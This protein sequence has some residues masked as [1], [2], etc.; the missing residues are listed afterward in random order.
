[1]SDNKYRVIVVEDES[2][3]AK[4]IAKHIE[5]ENPNFKVIGIYSNGEDA[6]CAVKEE[7]PEVVFTDISMPVMTGLELASK[8]HESFSH[9]RCV[10]LTG[11]ADFEYAKE[12]L[13][14]N[15]NDYLLKPLDTEE[16]RKVLKNLELSL[17]AV[18]ADVIKNS[19]DAGYTPEE[20]VTI[21]KEYVQK[22]YAGELDLN[23]I[24]DNLGFSSSY[25][26]KVFNKVE[27]ITP[28]KY[29][30]NYRMGIA[31]QLLLNK[32]LTIAQ[33]AE[34]VGYNDPFH[35][36]KSFKQTYGISPTD[37]RKPSSTL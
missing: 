2:L 16:L 17:S 18:S 31:K 3:I 36:S 8:I 19:S 26:T 35:F 6:F 22:N 33:V 28:S 15:V 14:Y 10:I 21:V 24:A 34:C 11:Y 29:I 37:I 7:L 1:M 4:N 5:K 12:A 32:D 27:Q 23:S 20:I 25:L 30:R 13:H 9:I